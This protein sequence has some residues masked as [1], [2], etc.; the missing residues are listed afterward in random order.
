MLPSVF[1]IRDLIELAIIIHA[2]DES[3]MKH[4]GTSQPQ[5]V[6]M[7]SDEPCPGR[8]NSKSSRLFGGPICFLVRFLESFAEGVKF[9]STR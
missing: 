1:A 3:V 6:H 5:N 9:S 8:G 4:W 7:G 2:C